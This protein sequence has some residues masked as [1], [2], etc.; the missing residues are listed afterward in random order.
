MFL[1]LKVRNFM[2]WIQ[3][4]LVWWWWNHPLRHFFLFLSSLCPKSSFSYSCGI[5]SAT[6]SSSFFHGEKVSVVLVHPLPTWSS[7]AFEVDLLM[8]LWNPFI[9]CLSRMHR[10][11]ISL[12]SESLML[13]RFQQMT[14]QS[15]PWFLLRRLSPSFLVFY[16][17]FIYF[18][19]CIKIQS[20]SLSSLV[21]FLIQDER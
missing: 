14:A 6:Y 10:E 11:V 21:T 2:A 4:K 1:T 7:T 19:L 5:K 15:F 3:V 13:Q 16:L 8:P 12:L 17:L 20:H 18:F 9:C